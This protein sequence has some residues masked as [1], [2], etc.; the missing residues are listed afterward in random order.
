MFKIGDYTVCPGHG[1]GQICDIEEREFGGQ[2]KYFYIIKIIANGM[3]VMVPTDSENGV[4]DLVSDNEI[5]QVYGLLKDHEIAI[6]TS[7]WNRRYREYMNKI[8]TGSITEIAE[9]LR[10]LFLLK[11]KKNLSFGEKK[12]L[13]Q[14]RDLISQEISLSKGMDQKEVN[15][16][17][18]GCFN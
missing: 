16:S 11:D 1:V 2:T 9:V 13:E 6:D 10:A 8:K 15:T 12:M 7:T 14:C 3:T 5:D 4:R 18:D 17:I